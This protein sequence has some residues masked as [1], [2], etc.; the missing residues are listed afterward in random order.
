MER[1]CPALDTIDNILVSKAEAILLFGGERFEVNVTL[2]AERDSAIYLS[3][4][5]SG[6]EI[7]RAKADRDSIR[8]IDR[9][10]RVVYLMPL[11]KRFGYQHPVSYVDLENLVSVYHLCNDLKRSKETED[12]RLLFEFDGEWTKKRILL[13][14]RGPEMDKF[15]FIHTRTGEYLMGERTGEGMKIYSNFMVGEFEIDA[16]K[17]EIAYNRATKVDMDVNPRRYTFIDLQ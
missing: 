17:G 13:S 12:G 2:F 16:R 7:I 1:R 11:V 9:L 5:S 15:E 3:A 10:N 8:V 6:F 4:V 14:G